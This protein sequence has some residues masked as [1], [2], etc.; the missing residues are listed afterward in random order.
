M[1][2]AIDVAEELLELRKRDAAAVACVHLLDHVSHMLL[3]HPHPHQRQRALD[4]RNGHVSLVGGVEVCERPFQ[5]LQRTR[6]DRVPAHTHTHTHTH[7]HTSVKGM[8]SPIG[9]GQGHSEEA[10]DDQ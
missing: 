1:S 10:A 5:V 6:A 4:I 7:A 8:R 9:E 2:S 3:R